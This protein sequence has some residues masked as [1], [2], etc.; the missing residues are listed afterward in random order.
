MA[1]MD[2]SYDLNLAAASLRSS[3]SD[4]HL[5]LKA[6]CHELAD[7]LGARLKI[8]RGTGRLRKSETITSVQITMANELFEAAI[9]GS[10]LRCAVGHFSGG[11][12]IRNES[13]DMDEWIIRLLGALQDEAAHSESAR[14]ALENIVI[15][16][17]E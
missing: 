3:S 4:V 6:L 13:V 8:Q 11:V 1:Q 2:G 14:R 16:G 5:L 17:H 7:T 15:G 9:E 12:R 10:S